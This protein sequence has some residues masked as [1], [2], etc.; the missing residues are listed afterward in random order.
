MAFKM[1]ADWFIST[2]HSEYSEM[3][4]SPVTSRLRL[5][6][7]YRLASVVEDCI[8]LEWKQEPVAA[9]FFVGQGSN[10]IYTISL[11]NEVSGCLTFKVFL[12]VCVSFLYHK[13]VYSIVLCGQFS[14]VR[15][16]L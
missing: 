5:L 11:L 13:V 14:G 2:Q 7:T 9:G 1:E 16:A 3:L 10:V 12:S 8:Q 15:E 4:T 6:S